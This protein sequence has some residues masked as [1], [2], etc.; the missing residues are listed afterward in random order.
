MKKNTHMGSQNSHVGVFGRN[1]P[2]TYFVI[3]VL[4]EDLL[5][6]E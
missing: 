1:R 2:T 4:Y 3:Q 5:E 6:Y